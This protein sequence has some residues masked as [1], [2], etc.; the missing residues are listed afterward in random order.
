MMLHIFRLL[1]Y[2]S[3]NAPTLVKQVLEKVAFTYS[4]S[5]NFCCFQIL[6]TE[7]LKTHKN[8]TIS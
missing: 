5:Y 6:L 2:F 8:F 4:P 3:P 1:N 7:T